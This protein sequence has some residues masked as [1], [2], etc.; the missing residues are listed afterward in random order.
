MQW[1][2]VNLVLYTY[3]LYVGEYQTI[4]LRTKYGE[5]YLRS[6]PFISLFLFQTNSEKQFQLF[7]S[8]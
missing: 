7:F 2:Y 3:H 4:S 1:V 5:D 6:K 8:F